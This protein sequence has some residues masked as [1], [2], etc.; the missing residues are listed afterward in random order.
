MNY[1]ELY[2][3]PES[4]V[5]DVSA[6]TKKYFEL[7][8]KYHPDFYSNES[9]EE[10]ETAMLQSAAVNK[11][12]NIFKNPDKTIEYYLQLKN[13]ITPDEKY[14]LPPDFL[15][16]M[17]ELNEAFDEDETQAKIS[18]AEYEASLDAEIKYLLAE[19]K[20]SALSPGELQKLKAYYY[21][22]KYLRRIGERSE[23]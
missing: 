8:K 10:K 14:S 20:R 3:L 5:T 17:M 12:Y 13:I 18:A 2:G 1:F 9:E 7:Q 15:M 23:S 21:K 16:E 22:K 11:A 19:E 4:P 6:V